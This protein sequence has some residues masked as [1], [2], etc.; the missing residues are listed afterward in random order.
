MGFFFHNPQ[1]GTLFFFLFLILSD[2]YYYPQKKIKETENTITD[3]FPLK[4]I[5]VFMPKLRTYLSSHNQ[6]PTKSQFLYCKK[7]N[8]ERKKRSVLNIGQQCI[9]A[10][11]RCTSSNLRGKCCYRYSDL[12]TLII[13]DT[14]NNQQV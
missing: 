4:I 9:R 1:Y 6:P 8:G 11:K 2:F 3:R 10:I 12:K 7:K 5:I 14:G 13:T